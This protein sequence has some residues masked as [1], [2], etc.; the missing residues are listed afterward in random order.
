[1]VGWQLS[2]I[3]CEIMWLASGIPEVFG[4]GRLALE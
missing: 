3:G 1:M 2:R 4:Y